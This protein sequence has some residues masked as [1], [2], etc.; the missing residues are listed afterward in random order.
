MPLQRINNS[1][2]VQ[3]GERIMV[4]WYDGKKYPALFLLS[5]I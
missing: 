2:N 1:E 5:G 3:A 4:H